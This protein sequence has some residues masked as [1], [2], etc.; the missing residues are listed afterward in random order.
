M[1]DIFKMKYIVMQL[2][3]HSH[4]LSFI[5]RNAL[6]RFVNLENS[7]VVRMYD[8][9]IIRIIRN[10][11]VFRCVNRLIIFGMYAG[12]IHFAPYDRLTGPESIHIHFLAQTIGF[13]ICKRQ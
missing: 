1:V 11:R 12:M 7:V 8:G 10:V 2:I 9:H 3:V 5:I 13:P 4:A 6:V